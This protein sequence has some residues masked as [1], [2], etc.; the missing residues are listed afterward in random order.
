MKPIYV[1]G[2]GGHGAVVAEVAEAAGLEVAGFIDDVQNKGAEV[3]RWKVLGGRESIPRGAAAV[4]AIG[5]NNARAE[6]T[7]ESER[8]GWDLPVLIHPSAVVSPSA[9]LGAGTV[10]VAGA[11]VNARTVTGRGCILNTSCSVD[12]DCAIGD[13][14]HISPG[15]RLAGD[16]S[17]GE[18]TLVGVG[19][20]ARPGVSI[21]SGCVVGAGS[22]IISDIPDAVTVYGCPARIHQQAK[23]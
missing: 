3:L 14:A 21:G 1:I 11:I 9:Q 10:V 23:E 5:D 17:V 4:V 18:R 6:I 13:F 7:A 12:H 15:T 19:S 16:V 8:E 20:C 22:V 2:A